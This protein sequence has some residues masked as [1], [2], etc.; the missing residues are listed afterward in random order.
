MTA[1][2]VSASLRLTMNRPYSHSQLQT[3]RACPVKYKFYYV[4]Q[5]ASLQPG[6]RH[7]LDFGKAW[8]EAMRVLY[9]NGSV[10]E[11]QEAFADAYDS[12]QYPNPLPVWS[13][14]K[15][16]INGYNAV[17][18][19]PERWQEDDQYWK[20]L[21]VEE[22]KAERDDDYILRL[23]LV[24]QDT[25]D[26]QV[27]GVDHKATGK[28]LDQ[29]YW[30][31]FDP[32]S[33]IRFYADYITRKYGHCGGFYINAASFKHRSKAVTPRSGPDKGRQLPAGD[34]FSF[35]RMLFNPNE[36]ALQLERDNM[37]YWTQRIQQDRQT[38]QWGYNDQQCYRGGIECEYLKICSAGYQWPR[39]RE[40]L[41]SYYRQQCLE[42]LQDGRCVLDAGHDGDH[43]P[44]LPPEAD[45]VIE[46]DEEIEEAVQ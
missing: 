5:L 39:D 38:G 16:F 43:L 13:Q 45:F 26:G 30:M 19:Y 35:A 2:C 31:G 32:D 10:L 21:S 46:T 25:R 11:A 4:D 22:L 12:S 34:W 18:E 37:V 40:L 3:Y 44:T 27:Y 8:H 36:N 41:L 23:D 9:T 14:G 29:K 1:Y 28:Y 17:G 15:S 20:V 24:V 7:D 33:Q 42:V 6:S